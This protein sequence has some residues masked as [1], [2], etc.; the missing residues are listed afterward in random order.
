[1]DA[2]RPRENPDSVGLCSEGFKA[3]MKHS[4]HKV[5][6]LNIHACR[7]IS[8]EAFEEVFH[9]NAHYPELRDLEISFC[10]VTDFILGSIFRACPSIREVN[11]FGCMKVRSVRVP[12]GVILAGVPNAQGMMT[13]GADD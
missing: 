1:M 7:H 3:L 5:R 2:T 10:E 4:G 9:E 13:E 11:V 12:R 8:R 6:Q